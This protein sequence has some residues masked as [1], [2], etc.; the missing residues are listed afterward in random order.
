LAEFTGERVVPGEV[1]ADLMNEHMARYAFAAR[2]SRMKR[3]LDAGCGSGYGSAELSRLALH[4]VGA[5]ISAEAIAFARAHYQRPNLS[6]ELATCSALPHRDAAFDLVVAF[7]V[8]E[9][10]KDWRQ[11][12]LEVRRVLAPGGQFVVSTPNRL[13]Y[14]EQRRIAGPNPFHEHEFD[15][16]EF[17]DELSAVFP[18]L[19]LFLEN[20]VEGVVFQPLQPDNTAQVRVDETEARPAQS[21]FFLAVCAHRPQ[22]GAPTFVFVPRSANVLREREQHIG[23]LEAELAKKNEWLEKAQRDLAALNEEHQKLLA[24]FR[25]QK[26]ELEARNRWAESLNQRLD[27]RGARILQLQEEVRTLAE[28]YEAKV[29]ELEEE[30][31]R[32]TQ[33]ALETE[34]RLGIELEARAQELVRCVEMLHETERALEERTH[35]ARRL[36]SEAARLSGQLAMVRASRWMRLGRRFGLGPVLPGE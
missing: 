9:H 8:I 5:D 30:N 4:V 10:I 24:M 23:L 21:H 15:F 7:E 35:W 16:D 20:H 18:H 11:F 3:V 29:S 1:D 19:S 13:Y 32:K 36:E 26:D 33:W 27:E 2:L 22:T 6:F 31:R 12:L 14:A 28:G 34:E 25:A 17:R